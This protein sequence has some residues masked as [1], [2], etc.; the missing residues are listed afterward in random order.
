MSIIHTVCYDVIKAQYKDPIKAVFTRMGWI[1]DS[2]CWLIGKIK[3]CLRRWQ[4]SSALS[5]AKKAFK[6]TQLTELSERFVRKDIKAR[7]EI[8]KEYEGIF[9][10]SE[11]EKFIRIPQVIKRFLKQEKDTPVELSKQWDQ[12]SKAIE[13]EYRSFN[14]Q[15]LQKA[16]K[17]CRT[18]LSLEIQKNVSDLSEYGEYLQWLLSLDLV[19]KQIPDLTK[20]PKILELTDNLFMFKC[21]GEGVSDELKKAVLENLL[22]NVNIPEDLKNTLISFDFGNLRSLFRLNAELNYQHIHRQL[23]KKPAVYNTQQFNT[24]KQQIKKDIPELLHY[25]KKILNISEDQ[26]LKYISNGHPNRII[27]GQI[28]Q[29]VEEFNNFIKNFIDH[30]AM[31]LISSLNTIPAGD[32]AKLNEALENLDSSHIILINMISKLGFYETLKGNGSFRKTLQ[33]LLTKDQ[34]ALLKNLLANKEKATP[35]CVDKIT[36]DLN[37][38]PAIDLMKFHEELISE[39]KITV[40]AK[41]RTQQFTAN[42]FRRPH[43]IIQNASYTNEAERADRVGYLTKLHHDLDRI[44]DSN[45]DLVLL[46]QIVTTQPFGAFID[47][48]IRANTGKGIHIDNLVARSHEFLSLTI[49]KEPGDKIKIVGEF[50]IQLKDLKTQ[51]PLKTFTLNATILVK[52]GKVERFDLGLA[53]PVDDDIETLGRIIG[54]QGVKSILINDDS[55]LNL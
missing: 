16:R 1:D 5:I 38:L 46:L 4:A 40:D 13:K 18:P 6:Y 8:I 36:S 20:S 21:K 24:F 37:N 39:E 55:N 43:I 44:A 51:L 25:F 7:R 19:N 53:D 28:G 48:H 35:P 12:S 50:K 41:G 22:R 9:S 14:D 15:F 27:T 47:T 33:E 23:Q 30:D 49:D 54:K 52:K 10:E 3:N 31:S 29:K 2:C 17:I 34:F 26:A 11:L 45:T 32:F 42:F